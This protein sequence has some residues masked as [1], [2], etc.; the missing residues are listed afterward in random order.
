MFRSHEQPTIKHCL[1]IASP[2]INEMPP[3]RVRSPSFDAVHA[4]SLTTQPA[5][6]I[7]NLVAVAYENDGLRPLAN[8]ER[9]PHSPKTPILSHPER[10]LRMSGFS[11]LSTFSRWTP[12]GVRTQASRASLLGTRDLLTRDPEKE[13]EYMSYDTTPPLPPLATEELDPALNPKFVACRGCGGY[14]EHGFSHGAPKS[15]TVRWSGRLNW[16]STVKRGSGAMNW[17]HARGRGRDGETQSISVYADPD[18]L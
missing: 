17:W 12:V 3:P 18:E 15:S 7:G 1:R 9:R 16:W 5:Q 13:I 6:G 11:R 10:V 14:H 8:E 4:L 2:D